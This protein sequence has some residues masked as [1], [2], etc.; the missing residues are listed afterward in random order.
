MLAMRKTLFGKPFPLTKR[1][2][3]VA[4]LLACGRYQLPILKLG[5]GRAIV[6]TGEDNLPVL[7]VSPLAPSRVRLP[8]CKRPNQWACKDSGLGKNRV[9]VPTL[10]SVR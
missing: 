10:D 8:F 3:F 7:V 5:L 4:Y 2:V 1:V 6:Y 9:Y